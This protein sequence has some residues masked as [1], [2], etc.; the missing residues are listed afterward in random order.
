MRVRLTIACITFCFISFSTSGYGQTFNRDSCGMDSN[1]TLNKYEIG[2]VDSL[3]FH[4][5]ATKKDG[6]IDPKKGFSFS[7]KKMAFFSCTINSNTKGKGFISKQTFFDLIKPI[8]KGHAGIGLIKFT[9]L[10]K[11]NTG[12][13]DGIIIIDCPYLLDT[14]ELI[15]KLLDFSK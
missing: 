12:G 6:L 2:F 15:T 8:P 4:P 11:A 9:E 3:L 13:F 5:Y 7:S 1:P 14:R 10:E